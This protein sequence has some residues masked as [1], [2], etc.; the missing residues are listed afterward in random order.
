MTIST[1]ESDLYHGT[2]I[3]RAAVELLHR[4]AAA[5]GATVL[6]GVWGFYGDRKPHGDKMFRIVRRVPVVTTVIDTPQ[7]IAA[8]FDVVDELTQQHGL[9]TSEMVPALVSV[10][11]DERRGAMRMAR[12]HY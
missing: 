2:P 3:H 4:R 10:R 7:A 5:S 8:A 6:R 11:G 9:V 1:F 12:Y